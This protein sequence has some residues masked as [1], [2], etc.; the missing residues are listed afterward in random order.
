[1]TKGK[2][3]RSQQDSE[4]QDDK[5]IDEV[6]QAAQEFKEML[7]QMLGCDPQNVIHAAKIQRL[8][9]QHAARAKVYNAK[10]KS[11]LTKAKRQAYE[12]PSKGI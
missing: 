6:Q 9:E 11:E 3:N 12:C 2:A 4:D 10:V 5:H 8:G 7:T 1:M